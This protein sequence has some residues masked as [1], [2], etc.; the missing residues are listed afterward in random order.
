M[1]PFFL[2]PRADKA[3]RA[4][5]VC[6]IVLLTVTGC[7]RAGEIRIGFLG[8]DL[9]DG[10]AEEMALLG[11]AL[12]V[13]ELNNDGGLFGRTVTLIRAS[14]RG[15]RQAAVQAA[16]RLA[17]EEKVTAIIGDLPTGIMR[18]V[19]PV[20]QAN[21][22]VTISTG[23][24]GKGIE[25][26]GDCIF[27][28]PPA[29][30]RVAPSVAEYFT[31]DCGWTRF[32]L[33]AD[34]DEAGAPYVLELYR[35]ALAMHGAK[36]AA[37]T[38]FAPGAG[39]KATAALG[40]ADFDAIVFAGTSRNAAAFVAAARAAGLTKPIYVAGAGLSAPLLRAGA[41][42][43]GIIVATGA[44]LTQ[45]S[46]EQRRFL[47]AFVEKYGRDPDAAAARGYDAVCL[48]AAAMRAGRSTK[49]DVY[50]PLLA[51]TSARSGAAGTLTYLAGSRLP[52]YDPMFLLRVDSGTTSVI[53]KL[54]QLPR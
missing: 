10:G 36:V 38:T 3:R 39:G 43:A 25:D 37:A 40:G 35:A 30:E 2:R 24:L 54:S 1:Q 44:D 27:R 20:C 5:A 48:L 15:D 19:S 47:T 29:E 53:T 17:V 42:A 33:V 41:E 45:P 12:A 11:A 6:A 22:I 14:Y 32:A 16:T 46:P 4:A 9:T 49:V 52:A 31:A 7:A 34:A 13:D 26:A 51:A 50:L 21:R 23:A 28:L 8:S 18:V